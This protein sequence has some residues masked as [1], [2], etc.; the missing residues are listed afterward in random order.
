MC[1][2]KQ[3]IT[4]HK[5]HTAININEIEAWQY[6]GENLKTKG[7]FSWRK[8]NFWVSHQTFDRMSEGVFGHE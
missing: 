2:T 1:L 5:K 4:K 7:V 6:F 8:G 3:I